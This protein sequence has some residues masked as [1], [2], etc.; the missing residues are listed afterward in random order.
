VRTKPAMT[1]DVAA[2]GAARLAEGRRREKEADRELWERSNT[3]RFAVAVN[4]IER[5]KVLLSLV[6]P[7]IYIF[8]E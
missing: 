3:D 4:E 1:A 6:S 7:F 5:Q 2:G 8:L